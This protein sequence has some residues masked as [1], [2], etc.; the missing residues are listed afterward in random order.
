MV[1]LESVVQLVTESLLS[2]RPLTRQ[3]EAQQRKDPKPLLVILSVS[4][5]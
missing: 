5:N 1:E 4:V 2:P 3:E